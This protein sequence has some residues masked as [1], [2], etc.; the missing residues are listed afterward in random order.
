MT[1]NYDRAYAL[2]MADYVARSGHDWTTN[3]PTL[4]GNRPEGFI[5]GYRYEAVGGAE[6]V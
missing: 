4:W 3:P 2:E 5:H 1:Y 6:S